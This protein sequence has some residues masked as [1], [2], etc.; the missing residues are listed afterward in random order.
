MR[1]YETVFV[2]HPDQPES[3]LEARVEKIAAIVAEHGGE[4]TERNHWGIRQLAYPIQHET[5][6]NYM[7]LRFRCDGQAIARL[8]TELR[9]DH[10]VL[11]HLIVQ[12]EE[13][14]ERNEAHRARRQQAAGTAPVETPAAAA[15]APEDP[16]PAT[17]A[18]PAAAESASDTPA[19]EGNAA[20]AAPETPSDNASESE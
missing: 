15:S 14:R 11:R 16:A 18:G 4:I 8:D 5:R 7:H 3:E 20:D 2:L 10:L 1:K 19:G 6:G 9:L 13:W 17:T 12:D